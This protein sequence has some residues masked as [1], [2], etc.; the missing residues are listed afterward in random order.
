MSV[1]QMNQS[2]PSMT[3]LGPVVLLLTSFGTA[4][5]CAAFAQGPDSPAFE[6]TTIKPSDPDTA[7]PLIGISVGRLTL[8]AFT[9]KELMVYAHWVHP[10]QV[11]GTSGWMDTQKFDIVAKP[12]K[13]FSSQ[14]QLR[15]MLQA[16]L[17]DRFKL[18]YHRGQRELPAYALTLSKG[19][20]KMKP[21]T[22]GDGGPGFRLVF[23]G[24]SLPGRNASIAQMIFVLQTRALDRPVIDQTGLT[25]NFDFNLSWSS[26]PVGGTRGAATDSDSPD[27]FTAMQT[28][29]GLKLES[30]RAPVEV[31]VIDQAQKPDAN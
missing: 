26:D 28:Q 19:G 27:L 14:D 17:A 5:P 4:L 8:T 30:R 1:V 20:S 3:R 18:K 22:P 13:G 24:N 29:L 16:L 10:N 31:V 7:G 11:L 9:L 12:E 6:V 25:G 15:Q 2:P 21:R 23:Q